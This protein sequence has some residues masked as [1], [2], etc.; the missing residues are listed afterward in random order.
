MRRLLLLFGTLFLLSFHEPSDAGERVILDRIEYI[1]NLKS[2]VDAGVW[3]G[4]TDKKFDLP[5]VYYTDTNCYVAN[6]TKKFIA[7]YKPTLLSQSNGLTIFKSRLVDSI[8]FHMETGMTFG[9]KSS[10]YN[11][12]SPFMS[13]SSF[14][15]IHQTIPGVDATEQWATMV[16]HEYFHGFQ[17]KHPAHVAYF[18]KKI[19][20]SA[21]TLKST[22]KIYPW[23]KEGVDRE[24]NILLAAL[25]TEDS[26]QVARLTDSFFALRKHRRAQAKGLPGH[27]LATLE[28]AYE[29][30]EGTARYVEYSLYSSF[31][32]KQ[33]NDKLS[34]SDSA[35]HSYEY[36]RNYSIEKDPWL[37][38][39]DKTA[40]FY[41][42]GFNLVRLLD[43]LGVS[44]KTR[45]FKEGGLALEDIL[46]QHYAKKGG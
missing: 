21:D 37:Y 4:F 31:A 10:A 43:K 25:E 32:G 12:K 19:S 35:Y 26:R 24:N 30:M 11:Y 41:A 15:I 1:Y 38:L 39:S 33:P 6:P 27:D 9:N 13:C 28:R 20:V 18:E 22:Y 3:K 14:E 8:P 44:Y 42:T 29:T 5:L 7:I 36:F 34:K 45:L 40:Y 2:L 16:I 46:K 23:F 17:F